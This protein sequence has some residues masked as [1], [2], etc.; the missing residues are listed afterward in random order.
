MRRQICWEEK[1]E[2][3]VKREIRISF[4]GGNKIKWQFKR[5]DMAEWDYDSPPTL[6][7]WDA[8]LTRSEARYTRRRMPFKDLELVRKARNAAAAG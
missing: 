6:E 3:G 5:S 7:D 2:E 4:P 1:L 8:L